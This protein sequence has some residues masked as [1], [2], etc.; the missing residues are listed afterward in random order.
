MRPAGFKRNDRETASTV[1]AIQ[2]A[3][4]MDFFIRAVGPGGASNQYS[5][6]RALPAWHV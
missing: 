3:L 1:I 6:H 2:T 5:V 4:L